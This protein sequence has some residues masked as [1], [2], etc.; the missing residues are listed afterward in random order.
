MLN[1]TRKVALQSA[2]PPIRKNTM[3]RIR[4][5]IFHVSFLISSYFIRY[6]YAFNALIH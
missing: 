2:K 6:L 5:F 1:H 4:A 3:I